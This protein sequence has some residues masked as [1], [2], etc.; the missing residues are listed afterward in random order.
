M[1]TKNAIINLQANF[2]SEK[3]ALLAS[4]RSADNKYQNEKDRQLMLAKIR[5]QQ[6]K[7]ARED[8]FESAALVFNIAASQEAAREER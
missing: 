6:K 2:D 3:E 8:K 4:L 7:V 1:I 5:R